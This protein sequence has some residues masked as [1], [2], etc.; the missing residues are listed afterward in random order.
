MLE[1]MRE[2]RSP[3]FFDGEAGDVEVVEEVFGWEGLG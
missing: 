2:M 3:G 1:G